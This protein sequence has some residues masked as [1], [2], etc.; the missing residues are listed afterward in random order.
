MSK[1]EHS[2]DKKYVEYLAKKYIEDYEGGYYN[3]EDAPDLIDRDKMI[4]VEVVEAISETHARMSNLENIKKTT[5][6]EKVIAE[7]CN[8]EKRNGNADTFMLL[9]N[10]G[11]FSYT[12]QSVLYILNVLEKKNKKLERYESNNSELN[13]INLFIYCFERV[14]DNEIKKVIEVVRNKSKYKKTY[15][16]L[17]NYFL[18]IE[19]DKSEKFPI[20]NITEKGF[21]V[22]EE[23]GLYEERKNENRVK[24]NKN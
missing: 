24:E 8:E 4:G 9:G 20:N 10:L 14:L 7:I 12:P 17:V 22:I 5:T 18:I 21:E 11:S 16:L 19:K 13:E 6:R 1:N 3:R 23:N 2:D 15:V